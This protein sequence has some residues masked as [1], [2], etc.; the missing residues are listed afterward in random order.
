MARTGDGR[1]SHLFSALRRSQLDC[2]SLC[3]RLARTGGVALGYRFFDDAVGQGLSVIGEYTD[4]NVSDFT[5]SIK[6]AR[7]LAQDECP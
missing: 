1:P 7:V 3:R 4:R 2:H 5:D 6:V